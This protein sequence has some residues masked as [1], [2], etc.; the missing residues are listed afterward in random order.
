VTRFEPFR[1][2]RYH[3][4][5]SRSVDISDLIAPPYDVLSDAQRSDLL[6]RHPANSVRLDFPNGKAGPE[7]YRGARI[8]LDRWIGNSTLIQDSAPTMTVYRMTDPTSGHQTTGV[9]GALGLEHPGAGDVLP[10]EETTA[11]DKADRLSLIRETEINTSPIWVL[12]TA[13]GLG[14]LCAEIISAT[15]SAFGV[16]EL[17]VRHES[18]VVT[19]PTAIIRIQE[20]VE[21]AP[22]VVADGHHRLETALAYESEQPRADSILALVVELSPDELDVRPIHRVIHGSSAEAVVAALSLRFELT[23]VTSD[24]D[25]SDDGPILVVAANYSKDRF[26]MIPRQGAFDHDVTL[27][28]QRVRIAMAY[29]VHATVSFHHDSAKVAADVRD[30]N[31]TA[32]ILLRPATVAQIRSVADARTRMPPKT[33]FFYPK[34][35]TGVVFRPVVD[36]TVT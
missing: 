35:R 2:L 10:H 4:T 6:D 36:R 16:D 14:S 21:S 3:R 12:S 20:I 19:D 18:W 24:V 11:K 25:H 1:G 8:D 26:V 9:F 28:S 30:G 7:A 33:T 34:P 29:A 31:A 13:H 5:E 23:S 32:A 27:D 15:P 22:V 17:G